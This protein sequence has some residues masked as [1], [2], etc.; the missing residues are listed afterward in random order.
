MRLVACN[1]NGGSG[2]RTA[3]AI[4]VD[5]ER[6]FGIQVLLSGEEWMSC[7]D[8]AVLLTSGSVVFWDSALPSQFAV[9]S[10][11]AKA[12]IVFSE[13][14]LRERL[15][16]DVPL[17]STAIEATRGV[18][19]LLRAHLTTLVE[20]L[21]SFPGDDEA[22]C[23]T[24]IDVLAASLRRG[25][26]T[27]LTQANGAQRKL[28]RIQAFVRAHLADSDMAPATIAAQNGISLRYLHLLFHATGTT[29]GAWVKEQRLQ[30]CREDL[31]AAAHE[32]D[33]VGEIAFRHGLVDPANFS[34]DF[35]R[36]FGCSPSALRAARF[37]TASAN[38]RPSDPPAAFC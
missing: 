10:P 9:K 37:A 22:L 28:A 20:H 35:K 25:M 36:R 18:G 24:T 5:D 34:R 3:R 33:G 17:A 16:R 15:P 21:D 4:R 11:L 38:G 14:L 23:N 1:S 6:R 31:L 13:K 8:N 32:A 12:T 26:A 29:V 27:P 19:A 30:R 7:G 2:R